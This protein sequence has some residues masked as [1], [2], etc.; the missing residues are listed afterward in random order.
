MSLAFLGQDPHESSSG[1]RVASTSSSTSSLLGPGR[2]RSI[3]RLAYGP[4]A[5]ASPSVTAFDVRTRP[6][7]QELDRNSLPFPL[8]YV[9]TRYNVHLGT[10]AVFL[11]YALSPDISQWGF[12]VSPRMPEAD[13]ELHQP[14]P[15]SKSFGRGNIFSD[16]GCLNLGCLLI[17]VVGLVTLL[18]H[19][20]NGPGEFHQLTWI[21]VSYIRSY[22]VPS[23]GNW[24]L[25]DIDTPTSAYT[26]TS[27][28]GDGVEMELVF[29]DEF[30][31]DGRT[32]YAGDDPYWEAVDLHYWVSQ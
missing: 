19:K 18:W 24:G 31:T 25:I 15:K 27:L 1:S 6:T 23:M 11:Q 32:F 5:P 30:N 10:Y 13:D 8:R 20:W 7:Q 28:S 26:T 4:I 12:N 17:L 9:A 14:D 29:S 3:P 22:Q 21:R 2:R 16:R